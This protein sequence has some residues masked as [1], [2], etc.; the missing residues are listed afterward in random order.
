[1]KRL[2]DLD[3]GKD[4]VLGKST[5]APTLYRTDQ[6][7]A[8]V[9]PSEVILFLDWRNVPSETTVIA[10]EKLNGLLD[11][12][13]ATGALDVNSK[14][15]VAVTCAD[16]T[17]YTGAV[18]NFASVFPAFSTAQENPLAMAAQSVITA[19]TGEARPHDV[20]QFATD[21]GHLMEAGI[22]T[23]GFGPGDDRLAHTNQERIAIEELKIATATYAPL[24]V[25]LAETIGRA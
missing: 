8:N 23:V 16:L 17:T 24:A 3:L 10:L 2:P 13:L 14:P 6:V 11:D 4:S 21:G 9:I 25:A 15:E 20:W 7:S 18:K 5:I 12:C 19:V 22:P 1:L